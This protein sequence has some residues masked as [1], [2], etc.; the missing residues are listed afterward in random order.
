MRLP[1]T[2]RTAWDFILVSISDTDIDAQMHRRKEHKML[3]S[4]FT[5][6]WG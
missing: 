3:E 5:T 4:S 6:D 2:I 1:V